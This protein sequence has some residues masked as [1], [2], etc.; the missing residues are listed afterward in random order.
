[1]VDGIA[2]IVHYRKQR[3]EVEAVTTL[4][5]SQAKEEMV[6][7]LRDRMKE[8]YQLYYSDTQAALSA[9]TARTQSDTIT[10]L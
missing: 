8:I 1:V 7:L 3:G 6:K 2:A 9:Q 5:A 4:T 10:L